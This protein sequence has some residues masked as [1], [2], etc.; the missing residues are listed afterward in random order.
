MLFLAPARHYAMWQRECRRRDI[1]DQESLISRLDLRQ[2]L[3]QSDMESTA[4]SILLGMIS[5]NSRGRRR[6][7]T[8][9][10]SDLARV[11][12]ELVEGLEVELVGGLEVGSKELRE[13]EQ[14][15]KRRTGQ[16]G[17]EVEGR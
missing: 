11:E 14:R 3:L 7:R 5:K 4:S 12:F 8:W 16:D 6:R 9:W 17:G 15:G 1:E 10:C 2:R 13:E